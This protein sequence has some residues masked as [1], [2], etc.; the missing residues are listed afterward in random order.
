MGL[1]KQ[2]GPAEISVVRHTSGYLQKA[3]SAHVQQVVQ[4]DASFNAQM[5]VQPRFRRVAIR[6][7]GR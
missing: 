5:Y 4:S 2:N 1:A 3:P 6:K 7:N